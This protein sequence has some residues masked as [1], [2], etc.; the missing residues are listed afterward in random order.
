VAHFP[1]GDGQSQTFTVQALNQVGLS[2]ASAGLASVLSGPT[3]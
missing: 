2:Q 3:P 1:L